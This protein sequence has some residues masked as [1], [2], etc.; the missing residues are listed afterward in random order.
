MGTFQNIS[1]KFKLAV[2]EDTAFK[3]NDILD[4]ILKIPSGKAFDT[5]ALLV[6]Y[7]F[8]RRIEKSGSMMEFAIATENMLENLC[9]MHYIDKNVDV[10]ESILYFVNDR[11]KLL[12]QKLRNSAEQ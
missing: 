9:K 7:N 1:E 11:Q 4:A 8:I 12:I 2:S 5:V 10:E 3:I 6:D